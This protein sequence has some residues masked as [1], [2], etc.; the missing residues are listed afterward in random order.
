M[1]LDDGNS[2]EFMRLQLLLSFVL[3]S[4]F[5]EL[6]GERKGTSGPSPTYDVKCN[7][8]SLHARRDV[9]FCWHDVRVLG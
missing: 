7:G 6:C 2:M 8:V 4:S 5:T 3:Q 9:G 1:R